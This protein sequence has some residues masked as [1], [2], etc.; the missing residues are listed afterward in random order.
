MTSHGK[1]K[2][3]RI[4]PCAIRGRE[5][6]PRPDHHNSRAQQRVARHAEGVLLARRQARG[7]ARP[8]IEGIEQ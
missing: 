6:G 8:A 5:C 3:G 4:A 2:S 7:C 1:L